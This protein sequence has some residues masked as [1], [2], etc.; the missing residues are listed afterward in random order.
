MAVATTPSGVELIEIVQGGVN[1]QTT[2]QAIADLAGDEHFKGVYASEAA[3][4]I[5][6]PSAV[7][8]DYA[9][10]DLGA[11]QDVQMFLWDTDDSEWVA[12]GSGGVVPDSS[13]TVK[14]IIE[15]ATQA[16]TNTGTDDSRALTPLKAATRYA[17]LAG[18]KTFPVK[19]TDDVTP[20]AV[21]TVFTFRMPYA[22]T[23][24]GIRASLTT[25]Q[26]SGSIFTVDVREAGVTIL[27]TLI[28]IDNT[29]ETSTTAVTPP[30]I[31]D[32][33]LADN[34]KMT[35]LVTQIGNGSAI[36]LQIDFIG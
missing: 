30:V 10:V 14:G 36:G 21:A 26:A 6:V 8:G 32:A 22:M 19:C 11:G 4:N 28:T 17:P 3:L 13:E 9:F 20:L 18:S 34:A 15:I 16:E 7:A 33:S 25:A 27:S 29:E 2:L 1:K 31:S 5:A 24:T 23:L 35:V 12:G